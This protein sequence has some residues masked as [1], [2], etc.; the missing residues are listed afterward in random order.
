MNVMTYVLKKMSMGYDIRLLNEQRYKCKKCLVRKKKQNLQRKVDVVC[1]Q[2]LSVICS[3]TTSRKQN[4]FYNKNIL[5]TIFTYT[6]I[7]VLALIARSASTDSKHLLSKWMIECV[8]CRQQTFICLYIA[9]HTFLTI[10]S[11][12]PDI[13]N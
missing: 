3:L 13:K 10:N 11:R 9:N 1:C 8:P 12:F 2:I 6:S 5:N 4:T 7:Y